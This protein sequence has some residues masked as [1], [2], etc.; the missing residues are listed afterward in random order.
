MLHALYVSIV[1]T[2]VPVAIG[3][4]VAWLVSLGVELPDEFVAELVAGATVL[5]TLVYYVIARVVERRFPKFSW[6]LGSGSIP[7]AYTDSS[8]NYTDAAPI[9]DHPA[10]IAVDPAAADIAAPGSWQRIAE[11][12]RR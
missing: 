3:A 7:I 2:G 4:L 5:V 10:G 8:R 1:R 9:M 12:E 11:I 6:L